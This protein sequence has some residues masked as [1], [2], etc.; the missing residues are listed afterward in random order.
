MRNSLKSDIP[1]LDGSPE[2][3]EGVQ[4]E[5]NDE[6]LLRTLDAIIERMEARRALHERL[7]R[8]WNRKRR[9][10]GEFLAINSSPL[11][12]CLPENPDPG[13]RV[14]RAWFSVGMHL[15]N[16]MGQHGISH[17]PARRK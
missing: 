15:S 1:P 13:E 5:S 6:A 17:D 4:E 2:A 8:R 7:M 10:L 12:Q 9:F 16:A 14:F 11:S 3:D